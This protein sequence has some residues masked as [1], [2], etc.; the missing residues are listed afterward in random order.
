[1]DITPRTVLRAFLLVG[2]IGVGTLG[3]VDGSTTQVVL[4]IAAVL[5]GGFGLWYQYTQE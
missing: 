5:L 4:G 1:M 3:Y 2:G